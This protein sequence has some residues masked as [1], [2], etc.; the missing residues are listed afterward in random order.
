MFDRMLSLVVALS[1]ALLVWLYARSRHQETI[2][3]ALIPVHVILAEPNQG[4]FEL[5][6]NGSSRVLVSFAGPPSCMR[7]LRSL[8]QRGAVQVK[9][10]LTVPEER[11]NDCSYRETVLIDA[12][13]VPVPPGVTVYVLEGRNT[14]PV[15]VHRLVERRLTVRL[16]T[17]GDALPVAAANQAGAAARNDRV[18][19]VFVAP[20]H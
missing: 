6:M 2:E 10:Q 12:D 19:V 13:D 9:C 16:E 18:E 7:E 5:E 20:S 14:V 15:T 8:L 11:Q 4:R 3:D 17:A 1:L